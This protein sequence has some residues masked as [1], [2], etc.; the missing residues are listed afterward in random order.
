MATNYS[1]SQFIVI[2][3]NATEANGYT[4]AERIRSRFYKNIDD[5]AVKL[6]YVIDSSPEAISDSSFLDRNF[7]VDSDESFIVGR[8]NANEET[9]D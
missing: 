4:I 8:K 3:T 9:F 5:P 2:L 7:D 6:N 1:S